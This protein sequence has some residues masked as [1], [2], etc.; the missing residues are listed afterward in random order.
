MCAWAVSDRLPSCLA[1]LLINLLVPRH[2]PPAGILQIIHYPVNHF[3]ARNATRDL[4]AQL[5]GRQLQSS[6]FNSAEV[7]GF[8]VATLGLSLVGCRAF[9]TSPFLSAGSRCAHMAT[10]VH[11]QHAMSASRAAAML[12]GVGCV[13]SLLTASMACWTPRPASALQVITDLGQVFKLIGG[14]CGSFFI[15]GMPGAFCLQVRCCIVACCQPIVAPYCCGGE[16]MLVQKTTAAISLYDYLRSTS[17]AQYAYSKHI[18]A[19][20]GLQESLLADEEAREVPRP[21]G[22]QTQY[23]VL[24]SKLFWAGVLLLIFAVGLLSLTIYSLVSPST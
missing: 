19:R 14:S 1:T 22:S 3:P 16:G 18:T 6:A 5:T 4:L 24:A 21:G 2:L 20:E 12:S 10:L 17:F 23:H 11:C 9:T 7:L 8:F 15:F 13:H